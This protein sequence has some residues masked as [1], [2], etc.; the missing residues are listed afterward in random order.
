VDDG[1]GAGIAE[2]LAEPGAG[3]T[4]ADKADHGH[5]GGYA[6]GRIVHHD[7]VAWRHAHPRC[8]QE[9]VRR[10]LAFAHVIAGK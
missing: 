2:V 1:A 9:Q 4:A 3:M 10:R 6:N 8:V 7:T 5:A